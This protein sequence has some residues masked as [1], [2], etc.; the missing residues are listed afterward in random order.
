MYVCI[1]VRSWLSGFRDSARFIFSRAVNIFISRKIQEIVSSG[2]PSE[3][4]VTP[5]VAT[6]QIVITQ[7]LNILCS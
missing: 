7:F 5:S 3:Y 6:L 2:V 4:S 1:V